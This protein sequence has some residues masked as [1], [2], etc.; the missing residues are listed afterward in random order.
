MEDNGGRTK[1]APNVRAD[2][3][4]P[5]DEVARA[6]RALVARQVELDAKIALLEARIAVLEAG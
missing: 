5:P 6:I 3:S 2:G 4:S 1:G